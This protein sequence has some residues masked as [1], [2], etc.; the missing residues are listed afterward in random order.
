MDSSSAKRRSWHGAKRW[1]KTDSITRM[2]RYGSRR[3]L[4]VA[5]S[6][7]Y[8]GMYGIGRG[9]IRGP[10][11]LKE[12]DERRRGTIPDHLQKNDLA[13]RTANKCIRGALV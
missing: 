1:S 5:Y 10:A 7:R 11:C 6:Y 13:R 3:G 8:S 2:A 12:A 9:M 4:G